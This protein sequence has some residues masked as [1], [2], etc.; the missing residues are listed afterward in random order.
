MLFMT[1][2]FSGHHAEL[3]YAVGLGF[4]FLQMLYLDYKIEKNY[5]A[6]LERIHTLN[7]TL[8]TID[9]KVE[10]IKHNL[11]TNGSL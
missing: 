10:N 6:S 2:R 5:Q 7:K 4:G 11:R 8:K 9:G 3:G 1:R